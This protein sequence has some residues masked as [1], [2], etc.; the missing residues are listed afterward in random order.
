[1]D[2]SQRIIA[3]ETGR[4]HA[5]SMVA[6]G[7]WQLVDLWFVLVPRSGLITG[8]VHSVFHAAP[9]VLQH[10]VYPVSSFKFQVSTSPEL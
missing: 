1:M 5:G 8:A 4:D 7:R 2:R 3:P 10:T 6:R 9:N